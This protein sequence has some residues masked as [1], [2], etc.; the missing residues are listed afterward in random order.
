MHFTGL[1]KNNADAYLFLGQ[2]QKERGDFRSAISSINKALEIKTTDDYIHYYL[3]EIYDALKDYKNAVLAYQNAIN[4]NSNDA[5]YYE[6]LGNDYVELK[7]YQKAIDAYKKSL[8]IENNSG[9]KESL[10]D[11]QQLLKES[12]NGVVR[13]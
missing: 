9:V 5:F 2:S 11:A 6:C 10:K 13:G 7:E 3:G 8:K 1:V 4:V 12:K